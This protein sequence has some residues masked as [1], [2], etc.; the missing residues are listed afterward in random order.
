MVADSV[1]NQASWDANLEMSHIEADGF[2]KFEYPT[3]KGPN[4][5][6]N[7]MGLGFTWIHRIQ[8]GNAAAA[9]T[10]LYLAIL[11]VLDYHL[12][13]LGEC[14]LSPVEEEVTGHTYP[15]IRFIVY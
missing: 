11:F 14:Q 5:F 9:A 1:M 8:A 6:G 4:P 3:W 12:M 10:A 7:L 13:L 15:Y 2:G